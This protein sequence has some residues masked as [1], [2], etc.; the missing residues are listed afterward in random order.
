MASA[1]TGAMAMNTLPQLKWA[2]SQPPTI[3]PSAIATPATAPHRPIARARSRR[4][5][6]TLVSSE[7]VAGNVIAAPRPMTALAAISWAA[8]VVKPPARLAAP[9]TARPASS[10][11]LR[12]N[13]S[14]RLPKVSSSA[15]KTRL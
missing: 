14:D 10:M 4:S 2:S 6:K 11:P 1:A 3:G 9:T 5:V 7:S 8:L 12:P 13:R 15:A